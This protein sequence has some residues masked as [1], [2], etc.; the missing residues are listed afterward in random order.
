LKNP[1][2]E[3]IHRCHNGDL[4]S[5]QILVDEYNSYAYAL[6]FRSL[7]DLHEAQDVVQEAFIRVW[8]NLHKF[9]VNKK[10]STWFY[11]IIV[12]LCYDHLKAGKRFKRLFIDE[13]EKRDAVSDHDLETAVM[14]RET[15]DNVLRYAQTLPS[16]QK[17]VFILRDIQDLDMDEVAEI[18]QMSLKALRSNL[19]YARKTIR[20]RLIEI[21]KN[22][23]PE[24]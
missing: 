7:G 22:E 9:D 2:H 4:T 11:R 8:H 3:I 10:F 1:S 15:A 23:V 24:N 20:N 5:F 19:Y 6:A 21:E 14:N 17:M 13:D 12:N 18:L 16:K